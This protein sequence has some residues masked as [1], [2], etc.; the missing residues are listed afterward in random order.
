MPNTGH[1]HENGREFPTRF[2]GLSCWNFAEMIHWYAHFRSM[3]DEEE[4][5]KKEEGRR[6]IKLDHH[7]STSFLIFDAKEKQG[8]SI[9]MR[10]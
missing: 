4:G 2:M 3:L 6:I 7:T 1:A 8:K 10:H 9:E 5:R